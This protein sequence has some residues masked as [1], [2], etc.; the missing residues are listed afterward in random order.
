MA[1][2]VSAKAEVEV[3]LDSDLDLPP[4]EQT[5]FKLAILKRGQFT[6]V[7]KSVGPLMNELEQKRKEKTDGQEGAP[8]EADEEQ[9]VGS[10]T[11]DI[12]TIGGCAPAIYRNL[13][14][15]LRGWENFKTE[16]GVEV[17][18]TFREREEPGAVPRASDESLDRLDLMV[19]MELNMKLLEQSTLTGRDRKN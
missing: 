11:K 13:S 19:A 12:E 10:S 4:E 15:Y 5:T 1:K 7:F 16:E 8:E 18:F 3:V 9:P 17:K 2:A 6:E 14:F